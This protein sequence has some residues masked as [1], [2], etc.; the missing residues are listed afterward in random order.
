MCKHVVDIVRPIKFN[1]WMIVNYFINFH[2]VQG[3]TMHVM[4]SVRPFPH[5]D[6]SV[7]VC[8]SASHLV[9]YLQS[10]YLQL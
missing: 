9:T 6:Y 1:F 5:R 8:K 7:F 10:A 2:P 3:T 4:S